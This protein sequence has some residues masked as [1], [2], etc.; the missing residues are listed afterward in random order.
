MKNENRPMSM[1]KIYEKLSKRAF[2]KKQLWAWGNFIKSFRK[3]GG[4][5]MP[6]YSRAYSKKENSQGLLWK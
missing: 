4:P 6:K 2:D 5:V 1:E 3:S